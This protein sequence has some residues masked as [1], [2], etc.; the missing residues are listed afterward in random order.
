[1]KDAE[2]TK[3]QFLDVA[4][5][6][7]AQ[8]GFY[9]VSIAMISAELGLT[10]QALLHHFG[11]KEGLYGA[12][13]EGISERFLNVLKDGPDSLG[14]AVKRLF[15]H[16]M[17]EQDDARIVMRELLDNTE[18]AEKS[19][20]WYLRPFL[21]YLVELGR[22][23]PKWSGESTAEVFDRIY[24]LVGAVNYWAISGPTLGRMYG[25]ETLKTYADAFPATLLKDL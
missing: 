4:K 25:P 6:L 7:F 19:R 3:V 11:S 15:T 13:L 22:K 12:V 24:Q 20:K 2:A 1:M 8:K 9:G 23:N 14:D 17:Q 10:K 16:M 18:R 5:K 21:D